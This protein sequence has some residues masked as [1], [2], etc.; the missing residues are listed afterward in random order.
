MGGGEPPRRFAR[1]EDLSDD[2]LRRLHG[3]IE[4]RIRDLPRAYRLLGHALRTFPDEESF[5]AARRGSNPAPDLEAAGLERA[6][7]QIQNDLAEIAKDALTVAGLRQLG[8]R[9]NAVGDFR[10]LAVEGFLSRSQ[11]KTLI[12]SQ[13]TRTNVQHDYVETSLRSIYQRAERLR[14]A[15]PSISRGLT[16]LLDALPPSTDDLSA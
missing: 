9:P 15:L 1:P 2:D 10:R 5:I 3:R 16:K 13:R 11:V 4:R 8:E 7:E 6:Y 12:D 14:A